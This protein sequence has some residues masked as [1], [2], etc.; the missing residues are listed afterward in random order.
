MRSMRKSKGG[1]LVV[2]IESL[3]YNIHVFVMMH[4][5]AANKG[6][7]DGWAWRKWYI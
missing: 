5:Q 4:W 6:S 1:E 2:G 3:L 7:M